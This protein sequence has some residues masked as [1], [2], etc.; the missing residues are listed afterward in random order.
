MKVLS[1]FDGISCARVAM[2]KLNI[3]VEVASF[4]KGGIKALDGKT[5]T[6]TS[7]AWEHNN[8]LVKIDGED[9][10]IR[11]LTP[12]ECERLQALP[13]GYTRGISNTQRYKTLGNAF[14][15][16]VIAHILSFIPEGYKR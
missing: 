7:S 13:D 15:A 4:N 1:L 5:P 8:H 6:L 10:I 12:V 2:S 11:K 14:N 9:I 3:P 16:D